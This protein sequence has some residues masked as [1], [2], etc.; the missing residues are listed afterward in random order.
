MWMG[1][2]IYM[3]LKPP[4]CFSAP[5]PYALLIWWRVRRSGLRTRA[6]WGLNGPRAGP[7]DAH[8]RSP[9][10]RRHYA[11]LCTAGSLY[12]MRSM[13]EYL[14]IVVI[15]IIY[16]VFLELFKNY[17]RNKIDIW[18]RWLFER[19]HVARLIAERNIDLHGVSV[20]V[21]LTSELIHQNTKNRRS[22]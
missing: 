2:N 16:S 6:A 22:L 1:Y 15:T 18:W 21:L 10:A 9:Q 4:G 13:H 8:T 7:T 20:E 14:Y 5:S 3:G 11:A 17:E 12:I 19:V